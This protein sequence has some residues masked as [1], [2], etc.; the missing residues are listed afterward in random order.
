MKKC[1]FISTFLIIDNHPQPVVSTCLGDRCKMWQ[2][3][4]EKGDGDCLFCLLP[5]IALSFLETGEEEETIE[6]QEENSN[7]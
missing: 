3:I 6:K 2:A 7:V 5:G 1:P 4:N